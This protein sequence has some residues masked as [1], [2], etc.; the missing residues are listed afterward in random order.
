MEDA[1][2]CGCVGRLWPCAQADDGFTDMP[3]A[4]GAAMEEQ[5]TS[6]PTVGFLC[7]SA[8]VDQPMR[9]NPLLTGTLW[10]LSTHMEQVT[11]SLYVNGFRFASDASPDREIC[12][13]LTPFSLVRNC[14]FPAES[15]HSDLDNYKMFKLS[16]LARNQ[17][18]YFGVAISGGTVGEAEEARSNWVVSISDAMRIV[19]LSLFP[20]FRISCHPVIQVP[21]T[22]T[23]L[24]A[25]YLIHNDDVTTLSV[26]YCELHGHRKACAEM[27]VYEN[28]SCLTP[29]MNIVITANTACSEKIGIN[30]TCFTID[31]HE[32]SARTMQ[33]RKLWLRAVSNLKVK[34]M[35]AAPTPD[36]ETLAQ[37]RSAIVEHLK[38][39]KGLQGAESSSDP[40][41]P[42]C[43]K[44]IFQAPLPAPPRLPNMRMFS[45]PPP[46]PPMAPTVPDE[47]P[48]M[49]PDEP[50]RPGEAETFRV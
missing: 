21:S 15:N 7:F 44:R 6:T 37:Y 3:E 49:R 8:A 20:P 23:R 47:G 34:L 19:T 40:L 50:H 25:G 41:L 22:R 12:H 43:K 9:G 13:S 26:L 45:A 48:M 16:F 31:Q 36:E 4:P 17:F 2:G 10:H 32:F 11:F 24:L 38:S 30:C 28:C 46:L 1:A 42:V 14:N 5:M 39:T 33:E 18:F 35:N 27:V 29:V